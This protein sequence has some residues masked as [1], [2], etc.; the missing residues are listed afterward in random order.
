MRVGREKEI[1][2]LQGL[3]EEEESQ[4]VAIYG[5]RR[6]GKTFLIREAFNYDFAFQHT[7]IYGATLREQ[8]DEFVES[9]YSAGMKKTKEIPNNWNEAFHLLER[10]IDKSKSKQK[11]VIFIDE[12]P[13]MD[14]HK[15]NFVRSLDHFW[16]SWTTA[17][18]DIILIICGSATSWIINNIIMNYGGLHNR[19]TNQIF[20][21]PF[22][23]KE[24]Q[25][26][27]EKRKLGYT[28]RQILEAYMALGGIPYY[29]SFL[30]KGQSVAQNFDR[31]FFP[32]EENSK[33][34]LMRSMPL[35]LKDP[36]HTY[37]SLQ[38]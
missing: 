25:E 36:R 21:E 33:K 30:K 19:L 24:C 34:N 37:P 12:M 38:H 26:Y 28:E 27:C 23:L 20:L 16:N 10:F 29:W 13:W 8:I 5:R 1:N 35:C 9:L 2:L 15:S 32:N 7:G 4:F 31:M 11:K 14:T 22:C 17:R 3:L 6:V 18:K